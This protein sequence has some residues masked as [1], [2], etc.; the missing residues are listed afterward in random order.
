MMMRRRYAEKMKNG[1][2]AEPRLREVR[3]Y[4]PLTPNFV[5]SPSFSS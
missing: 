1:L 4:A 3:L 5:K 2:E